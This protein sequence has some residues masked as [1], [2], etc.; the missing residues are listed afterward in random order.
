[1]IDGEGHVSSAHQADTRQTR[2]VAISNT[3]Q[4]IIDA[5]CHC[6]NRLEIKFTLSTIKRPPHK[7]LR[8][9]FIYGRPH[10][11]RLLELAPIQS[12]KRDRLA[13]AI[14]SYPERRSWSHLDDGLVHHLY[15]EKRHTQE[16]VAILMKTSRRTIQR[17]MAA[18]HWQSRPTGGDIRTINARRC[19]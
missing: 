5:I 6:L 18:Q 9:V 13:Y 7:V 12:F 16:E 10:L 3:D 8:Q 14:A 15:Y 11:V 4:T 1:M 17:H 19:P 2:Y